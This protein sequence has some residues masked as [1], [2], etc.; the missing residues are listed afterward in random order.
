MRAL[1]LDECHLL[2]GNIL[3]YVWGKTSE[4]I[5]VPI[6]N[7]RTRQTYYGAVDYLTGEVFV[8]G[9]PKGNSEHT[10]TFLK[11]LLKQYPNQRLL[12]FWDGATYHCSEELRAFLKQLN[13]GKPESE[14]QIHCICFAPNA[15][16]QNPIED[17]WL[18]AKTYLR[19]RYYRCE[20]FA[21]VKQ[22]FVK[23]LQDTG[24]DFPKLYRYG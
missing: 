8:K 13:G 14:W 20:T 5:E 19:Q 21:Q 15:P 17:I 6:L 7:T 18:Q 3:G 23:F 16:E 4:R 24:F 2:W 12:L 10:I 11:A 9:L 22:M 1:M